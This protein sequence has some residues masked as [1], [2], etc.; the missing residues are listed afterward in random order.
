M[1]KLKEAIQRV[2]VPTGEPTPAMK[3]HQRLESAGA[4]DRLRQ[5][6]PRRAT[7]LQT[8][9]TTEKSAAEAGK[10]VGIGNRIQAHELIHSSMEVAFFALSEEERAAYENNPAKALQTRSKMQTQAKIER[11]KDAQSKRPRNPETGKIEISDTHKQHLTEAV[12]KS[13][14]RR[15]QQIREGTYTGKPVGRPRKNGNTPN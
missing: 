5:L 7:L 3:L 12:T 2:P 14:Q 6:D 10:E 1:R 9:L 11:L 15:G 13:N 4:Y 8:Y